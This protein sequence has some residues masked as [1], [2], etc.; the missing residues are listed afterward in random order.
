MSVN[1]LGDP[2][3]AVKIPDELE[4]FFHVLVYYSVRYL[5]S[6][7]PSP[8]AWINT[9]FLAPG[10]PN[11]YMGGMK[12]VAIQ[13]EGRLTTIVPPGPLLF[14][15][16]MDKLLGELIKSFTARY[17]VAVHEFRQALTPLSSSSSSSA[18]SSP[19]A[20]GAN[21]HGAGTKRTKHFVPTPRYSDD[22]D[23]AEEVAEWKPYKPPDTTPT[24]E[25]RELARRVVDH[26]FTLEFVA[27]LLHDEGWPDDDRVPARPAPAVHAHPHRQIEGD[28]EHTPAEA[29]PPPAPKRRRKVAPKE[30]TTNVPA[31]TT[32]RPAAARRTRSQTR[33]A[34]SKMRPRRGKS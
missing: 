32:R 11:M 31:Q 8:N 6:N 10:M 30:T 33:A 5:C 4:S 27:T 29:A 17:K 18:N 12:A 14:D 25:E 21:P 9:Y 2:F 23:N 22:S 28:S 15:S 1:L 3:Q 34:S 26:E 16:P 24:L 20:D 13:R 7:C 19:D